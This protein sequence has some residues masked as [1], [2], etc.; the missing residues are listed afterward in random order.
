MPIIDQLITYKDI[1]PQLAATTNPRHR[2]ILEQLYQHSRGEVEEDLDAVL[3]TLAPDPVYRTS[4]GGAALNPEGMENVRRFYIEQIFGRGRHCLEY[5]KSRILVSDDAVVTEGIVRSVHWG[6][7]LIDTGA[8]VD[9]PDG[10]YLLTYPMLIVWPVDAEG[11]FLGEESWANR[12]G[13]DYIRK[14]DAADLPESFK[15]Y[16][17]QRRKERAAA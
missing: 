12:A 2:R 9:D 6:Q 1:E 16:V 4:M 15:G 5:R 10:Y 17:A 3:A 14:I 7:D 11:R 8:Q 13:D